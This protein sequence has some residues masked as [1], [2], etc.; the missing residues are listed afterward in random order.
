MITCFKIVNFLFWV[1]LWFGVKMTLLTKSS[2]GHHTI[3]A[4]FTVFGH[5]NT[6]TMNDVIENS[7]HVAH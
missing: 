5:D 1:E 3:L 2:F 7:R 6:I 4:L